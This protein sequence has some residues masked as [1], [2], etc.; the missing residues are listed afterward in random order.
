MHIE[1]LV[2]DYS[3]QVVLLQIL[4]KML[5]IGT[6][7]E[8]R[9]FEGKQDLLK[10][11]PSRLKGYSSWIPEDWRIVILVDRD[12]EDCQTLKQKL[13][14]IALD[15]GFIT[16]ATRPD[17][18]HFQI[19]NRI[20]CEELEAWFFGDIKAVSEAYPGVSLNLAQKANYRDPDGSRS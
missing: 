20:M 19:L 3:T 1:F 8:I 16:K 5:P 7:Y 6:E 11:L 15:A 13:E 9:I 12:N 14:Q 17:S 10:K 18:Q 4:S 2:E